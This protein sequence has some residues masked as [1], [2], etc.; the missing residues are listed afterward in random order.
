M[1]NR[2][3]M[4][5]VYRSIRELYD[6][7]GQQ[8]IGLLMPASPPPAT[9]RASSNCVLIYSQM[10]R[11]NMNRQQT[12]TH[13]A[14]WPPA[15]TYA[16]AGSALSFAADVVVLHTR[17]AVATNCFGHTGAFVEVSRRPHRQSYYEVRI[18]CQLILRNGPKL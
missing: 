1:N 10:T 5:G 13:L 12:P 17:H 15:A 11:D 4:P 2:R 6:C 8:V 16:S 9:K 3:G 7:R 18:S 14:T